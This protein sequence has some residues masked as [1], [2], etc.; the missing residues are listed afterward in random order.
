M[1]RVDFL[2]HEAR[3][4]A[5]ALD[6]PTTTSDVGFSNEEIL[7]FMNDAQDRM[8]TLLSNA[9]STSKPFTIEK[10]IS[11]DADQEEVEFG[12]GDRVA[13][14]KEIESVEYSRTGLD[15]DYTHLD[16]VHFFNRDTSVSEWPYGYY[17]R[18]GKIYLVPQNDNANATL[19]VLY[20]RQMDDLDVRRG[21]I[22]T[23]TGLTS[24]GF[25]SITL[26]ST[27]DESSTP[28]L[29]E[30]DYICICDAD[31]EVQVYNIPVG[32]YTTSTNVLTPRAGFTF[33]TG[34]AIAVNDYVTFHKYTTTHSALPDE[35]ERYLLQYTWEQLAM[36]D[37]LDDL[38]RIR[39]Q[40]FAMEADIVAN[41]RSQTG[42]VAY[43]P[44]LDY[45]EFF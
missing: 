45:S 32:T 27:A 2:I 33:Q 43:I 19:R 17:T 20:E 28:S 7:R 36:R 6:V 31:G 1:K 40:R 35:C 12:V 41:M 15:T 37:S 13:Y 23:V 3:A 26:D 30:I 4:L 24:T 11:L 22:S 8:Q 29:S 10:I 38:N 9:N 16:K 5:E 25:T 14:H 34:E 39:E 42:E 44:T 21:L 18:F